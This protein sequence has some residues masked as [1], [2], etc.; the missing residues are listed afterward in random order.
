MGNEAAL[1]GHALRH[2]RRALQ[3][4]IS[5]G[6]TAHPQGLLYAGRAPTWSLQTL[7]RVLQDEATRSH[8]LGW[9]DL[10]SGLYPAG[11]GERIAPCRAGD[12][13]A[14]AR[15]RAWWG[16]AVT[17]LHDGSS[18]SAP[19]QGLTLVAA[20]QECLV[21]ECTGS[22]LEFGTVPLRET[23]N[24]LREDPWCENR[25]KLPAARRQAARLLRRHRRLEGAHRRTRTGRRTAGRGRA[26]SRGLKPC[27]ERSAC[28]PLRA[29]TGPAAAGTMV[30]PSTTGA[31]TCRPPS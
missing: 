6:Q 1:L 20:E 5:A 26:G 14:V 2:G 15:A 17:S 31:A 4:A 16:D 8:R 13:A 28:C 27:P 24:A 9:I 12:A 23:L 22:T 11:D 10:R 21:A 7:R 3:T 25:R 29:S 19:L 30:A 18:S